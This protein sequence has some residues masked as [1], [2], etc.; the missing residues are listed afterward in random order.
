MQGKLAEYLQHRRMREQQLLRVVRDT[1]A[2]R[3]TATAVELVSKVYP[4]LSD[5]VM[6]AAITNVTLH[7][8]K[9]ALEGEIRSEEM[10][11]Q[12][13]TGGAANGEWREKRSG[14][15]EGGEDGV[16]EWEKDYGELYESTSGMVQR[17]SQWK[18]TATT[19]HSGSL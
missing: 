1:T 7:L 8:E 18:W 15:P 10:E 16:E 3:R 4:P 19:N 17:K 6:P 12:K 14:W 9:L 2:Q 11:A 5:A 13:A